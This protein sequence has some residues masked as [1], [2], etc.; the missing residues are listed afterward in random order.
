MLLKK[1]KKEK[2]VL[3]P[4]GVSK[5]VAYVLLNCA[6]HMQSFICNQQCLYM[7]A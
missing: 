4:T 1:N 7:I 3:Q 2:K 5:S 6:G